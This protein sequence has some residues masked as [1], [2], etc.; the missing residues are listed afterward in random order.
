MCARTC[1]DK[2]HLMFGARAHETMIIILRLFIVSYSAN[3]DAHISLHHSLS[4]SSAP[5]YPA[6]STLNM[7]IK[8]KHTG[9][10]LSLIKI[11]MRTMHTPLRARARSVYFS[12]PLDT[13][14]TTVTVHNFQHRHGRCGVR[15]GSPDENR[16]VVIEQWTDE[17]E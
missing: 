3:A 11:A 14:A 1:S 17:S 10:F 13:L 2:I 15:M 8:I 4:S 16:G 6:T 5:S 12:V 9:V 7:H